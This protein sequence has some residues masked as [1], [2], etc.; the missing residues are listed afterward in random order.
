MKI[1]VCL[2]SVPS[3]DWQPRV[4]ESG[5]GLRDRDAGHEMN[6]PDAY[7]LEAAL[8]LREQHGG[9]VVVCA[10]GPAGLAQVLREALARGADRAVA[11][12]DA[13]LADADPAL[14]AAA[15][16]VAL[17]PERVDLVLAGLQSAD[18]GHGQTG[19]LLAARLGLP[20]A[21]IVVGIEAGEGRVRVKREL[22]AGWFQW[23][24]LPLPALLTI[25]SGSDQ[26][27][28]A[29]LKGVMAARKKPI[30]TVPL[31]PDAAP[32]QEVVRLAVPQ[33]SKQTRW[34]EGTPAE[35]ARSLVRALREEAG[36]L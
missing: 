19:G 6:E 4:D 9:E 8:R 33:R 36:A 29:T 25:Q 13:R 7:A 28:Y 32:S 2:K 30:E 3:R 26:L 16:A 17:A 22:E 34:I 31:D 23:V 11:V 24:G 5:R 20:H 27:R 15:L 21:S 12:E 1:A 14:T 35:A 10:A 18:Q